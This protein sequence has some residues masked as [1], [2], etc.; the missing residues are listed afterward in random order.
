M[1]G[2][3]YYRP[4][5]KSFLKADCKKKEK[6]LQLARVLH[7]LERRLKKAGKRFVFIV[8][9]DK[10]TI[11]PEYMGGVREANGCNKSFYDLFLEALKRYPVRGFIRLDRKF[12]EAKKTNLLYYTGGTHWNDR[13]AALAGKLILKKLSTSDVS[14]RLPHI[15]FREKRVLS[16]SALMLSVNLYELAFVAD[17]IRFETD[18]KTDN[19]EPLAFFP[20]EWF[21]LRTKARRRSAGPLLPKT[22]IYRD[23][24]M[25]APLKFLKG[26]FEEIYARWSH[27]FPENI[28]VEAKEVA[29]AKIVII[30][31]VEKDLP[32]LQLRPELVIKQT[33]MQASLANSGTPGPNLTAR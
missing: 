16:E 18:V 21:L 28:K 3:L 26:S 2:W 8:A 32:K 25:T 15:D 14:Y 19:I 1:N 23:S 33:R 6:A 24:F 17:T 10:A 22:I 11:Y 30:E 20:S 13:G 31:I 5:I 9:P 27:V 7:R 12:M 29:A 4:A